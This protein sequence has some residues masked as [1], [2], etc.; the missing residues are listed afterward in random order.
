MVQ[1]ECRIQPCRHAPDFYRCVNEWA[2]WD[3]D[4]NMVGVFDTRREARAHVAA[5]TAPEAGS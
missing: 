3:S 2:V 4:G 5:L 1:C